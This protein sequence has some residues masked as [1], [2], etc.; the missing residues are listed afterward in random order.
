[1]PFIIL[2][3]STVLNDTKFGLHSENRASFSQVLLK[4]TLKFFFTVSCRVFAR[5]IPLSSFDLSFKL[6]TIAKVYN[7]FLRVHLVVNEATKILGTIS[8]NCLTQ[9][10][11]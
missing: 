7:P 9:T 6:I 11:E 2:E 3:V 1:M 4:S 8:K 5:S 10:L